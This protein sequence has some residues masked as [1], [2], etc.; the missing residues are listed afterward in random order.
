MKAGEPAGRAEGVCLQ[1]GMSEA[2][3]HPLIWHK[4]CHAEASMLV[5]DHQAL[6]NPGRTQLRRILTNSETR[7]S[8]KWDR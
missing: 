2:V 1:A 4:A 8:R 5:P 6:E 3:H 7:P